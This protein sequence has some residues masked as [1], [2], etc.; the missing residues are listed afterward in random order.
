MKKKPANKY[1]YY[2]GGS[3]IHPSVV[4][5]SAHIIKKPNIDKSSISVRAGDWD[6]RSENE[7]FDSQDSKV[8][9]I[10]IHEDYHRDS[11]F[12]DIALLFLETPFKISSNVNLICLPSQDQS[13]DNSRCIV[14]G[15]RKNGTGNTGNGCGRKY[16]FC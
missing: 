2:C 14:T 9:S 4:L 15:W 5:T 7:E 13:F 16:T 12:S 11:S 6:I 1:E 10:V 8:K 3:L